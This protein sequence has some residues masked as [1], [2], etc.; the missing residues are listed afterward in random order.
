MKAILL[1]IYNVGNFFYGL[2]AIK[3]VHK[4]IGYIDVV[5]CNESK[6]K[7]EILM[8]IVKAF[9]EIRKVIFYDRQKHK[10]LRIPLTGRFYHKVMDKFGLSEKYKREIFGDSCYDEIYYQHE[11][12]IYISI[13][14]HYFKSKLV[15]Y[16]DGYGLLWGQSGAWWSKR[17]S[18]YLV[19]DEIVALLPTDIVGFVKEHGI[20]VS[21][22]NPNIVLQLLRRN[23]TLI[24]NINDFIYK[25]NPNNSKKMAVIATEPLTET[26]LMQFSDEVS[27]NVDLI[28]TFVDVGSLVFV[29]PHPGENLNKVPAYR[30]KLGGDYEIVELPYNLK[31]L[32]FELM[33]PF[34]DSGAKFILHGSLSVIFKYLFNIESEDIASVYNKHNMSK[35]LSVGQFVLDAL[36]NKID[37][38]NGVGLIYD[39][40]LLKSGFICEKIN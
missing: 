1:H 9:P 28:K 36:Y 21:T 38:W 16:G 15:M 6:E 17:D 3:T 7:Y 30:E 19:P 14:K 39:N 31:I 24:E 29:K 13:L 2:A 8:S 40:N 33:I 5:F 35:N 18:R 32:P 20:R 12:N 34:V 26:R 27:L 25:F 37:S 11:L 22:I 23:K 4:E 10:K